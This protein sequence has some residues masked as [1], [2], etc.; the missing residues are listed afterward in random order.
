MVIHSLA[1]PSAP[2]LEVE[3]LVTRQNSVHP[4]LTDHI[5]CTHSWAACP[6]D[7]PVAMSPVAPQGSGARDPNMHMPECIR[8]P[9]RLFETPGEIRTMWPWPFELEIT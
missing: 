6:I 1:S 8:D 9:P 2:N 4:S 7:G 3:T 5:C